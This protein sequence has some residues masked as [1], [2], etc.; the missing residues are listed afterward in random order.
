MKT[1]AV[2]ALLFALALLVG[3]APLAAKPDQRPS[4]VS[5]CVKIWQDAVEQMAQYAGRMS[6]AVTRRH[7]PTVCILVGP[8]ICGAAGPQTIGAC[9]KTGVQTA[10]Q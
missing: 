4:P 5:A 2:V 10:A 8:H 3:V 9:V 6:I 1:F 7:G